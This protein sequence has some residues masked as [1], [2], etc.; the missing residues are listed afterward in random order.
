VPAVVQTGSR[1]LSAQKQD[2]D[3]DA[4]LARIPASQARS[5]VTALGE[6]RRGPQKGRLVQGPRRV[7]ASVR[8]PTHVPCR[9]TCWALAPADDLLT[10]AIGEAHIGQRE[11]ELCAH[12]A[13]VGHGAV[14]AGASRPPACGRRRLLRLDGSSALGLWV[15]R[16]ARAHVRDLDAA[17]L[18]FADVGVGLAVRA[19]C[20]VVEAVALIAGRRGAWRSRKAAL[21]R[22][23]RA[24]TRRRGTRRCAGAACAARRPRRE[25]RS[26][27]RW[28]RDRARLSIRDARRAIA[29][30]ATCDPARTRRTSAATA[31][32]A[33]HGPALMA[34]GDRAGDDSIRPY[35]SAILRSQRL[36]A[37]A[38]SW[39][40]RRQKTNPDVAAGIGGG[41][42]EAAGGTGV[43]STN[44][45][46]ISA[47]A[48][49]CQCLRG[50]AEHLTAGRAWRDGAARSLLNRTRSA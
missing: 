7:H 41:P 18:R 9:R 13:L 48:R 4:G 12:G 24:G 50:H 46:N 22:W 17:A 44:D 5:N 26:Q 36:A 3:I 32:I 47:H 43:C 14:G 8:R 16:I 31:G 25:G 19:A 42:A 28:H 45:H 29:P 21:L 11:A 1:S 38:G 23:D 35:N 6:R 39:R 34:A 2:L 27:G 10:A 20:R 15:G 49:I 30:C 40:R 37:L 33:L